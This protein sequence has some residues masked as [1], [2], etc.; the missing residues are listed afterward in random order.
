MAAPVYRDFRQISIEP[1]RPPA[2]IG[3]AAILGLA[4]WPRVAKRR[5]LPG[6]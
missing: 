2:W 5:Q 3:P 4:L 6:R 1:L